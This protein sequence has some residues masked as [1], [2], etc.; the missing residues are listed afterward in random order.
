MKQTLNR[1][2]LHVATALI[3]MVAMVAPLVV[4]SG[5]AVAS[6][7]SKQA[8]CDGAGL[9]AAE[10]KGTSTDLNGVI[11]AVLKVLTVI[12]GV[13]AVV[14]VIISGFRYITSGG[15]AAKVGSAK[16]ALVYALVGLVLVALAQVLVRFVFNKAT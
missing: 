5:T 1:L 9:N 4:V 13:A 14:M 2:K 6:S 12:V 3:G 7:A 10:C 11:S 15:D 16:S 8:I